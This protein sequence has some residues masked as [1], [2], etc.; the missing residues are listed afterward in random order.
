MAENEG[1]RRTDEA[2]LVCTTPDVCW[3]QI[4]DKRV[5]VPYQIYAKF[6]DVIGDVPTVRFAGEN[7]ISMETRITT[8]YGDEQ[9]IHGGEKSG[10]FKGWCR[11]ITH[12]STVRINGSF[13]IYHTATYWMNCNG[14]DGQGNTTGEVQ[15]FKTGD[16]P[17]GGPLVDLEELRAEEEKS[18]W[19]K[20][21]PWVHGALDVVGLIPGLGEIADGANA[22]VYLAEGDKAM[23]AIS[24]AAMIPIVGWG[25][26]GAKAVK[27]SKEIAEESVEQV[28]KEGAEEL[29]EQGVKEGSE[30]VVEKAAKE[31]TEEAG[32][33]GAKEG[34]DGA[35]ITKPRTAFADDI[36][37]G[38][39][40]DKHVVEKNEF[41]EI[42]SK[43]EFSDLI[44]N[45]VKNPTT[46]RSLSNGRTAYYDANS[47]TLVIHNPAAADGGTAFRPTGG[48]NY[49]N[50]LK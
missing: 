28:A 22:L 16:M 35:K 32:E 36:A 7:S 11:P 39:A 49:V 23:A 46:Q 17:Y 1:V 29:V 33:K 25:A 21:S 47:N 12:S 42:K 31:G 37:N 13:L 41:P 40:Y 6:T 20:A 34:T 50:G 43:G 18:W 15:F 45:T 3:T 48:I 38:H 4:G 19:E 30:E 27:I 14:P 24:A 26:T 44:D 2:F 10:V 9:G 5:L 8:V